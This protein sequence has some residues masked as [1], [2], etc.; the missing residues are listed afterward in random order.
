MTK[1]RLSLGHKWLTWNNFLLKM[2]TYP[3]DHY[4]KSPM[5]SGSHK[6]FPPR[7]N[8][9]DT[10]PAI[11]LLCLLMMFLIIGVFWW[12]YHRNE[13]TPKKDGK[14]SLI[15]TY[16]Q[17][18]LKGLLSWCLT[19]IT[20]FIKMPSLVCT[21]QDLYH[22]KKIFV[23][24]TSLILLPFLVIQSLNKAWNHSLVKHKH[25]GPSYPG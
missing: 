19:Q 22:S 8:G 16:S 5:T 18:I 9:I 23:L 21:R 4:R 13:K 11:Y 15:S 14:V 7:V 6:E 10:F 25:E 24:S 17:N 1:L 3:K 12:E 2:V 20:A